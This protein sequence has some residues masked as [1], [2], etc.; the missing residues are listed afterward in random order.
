MHSLEQL[1]QALKAASLQPAPDG[2]K[3]VSQWAKD[4]G[5]IDIRRA[6]E[7]LYKALAAGLAVK[8]K[9]NGK[10]HYKLIIK[11]SPK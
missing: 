2:F 5:N 10:D 8:E 3:S 11:K 6:R 4:W 1:Q 7:N 9:H